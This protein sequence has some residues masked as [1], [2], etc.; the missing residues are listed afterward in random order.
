M[1]F[2][3]LIGPWGALHR[4]LSEPVEQFAAGSRG[5]AI[6]AEDELVEIHLQV[7]VFDPALMRAEQPSFQE[8]RNPVC[9]GQRVTAVQLRAELSFA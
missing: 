6:E 7:F 3:G 9:L 2:D 1:V 4:L 5:A 8:R